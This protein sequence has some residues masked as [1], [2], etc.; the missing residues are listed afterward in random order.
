MVSSSPYISQLEVRKVYITGRDF[1][2][3]AIIQIQRRFTFE[4]DVY[5]FTSLLDPVNSRNLNPPSLANFLR[6]RGLPSWNKA[7]IDREWREQSTVSLAGLDICT[8]SVEES[9]KFI[10]KQTYPCG[11]PRFENLRKVLD[12]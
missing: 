5:E 8:M 1:Y 10:C 4:C 11:K 9:W 7:L 6:S 3:E 2:K 12:Y